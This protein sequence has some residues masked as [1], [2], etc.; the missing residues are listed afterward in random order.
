MADQIT[1]AIDMLQGAAP[2]TAIQQQQGSEEEGQGG[3]GEANA[4]VAEGT[5]APAEP[6]EQPK[7][8]EKTE[9]TPAPV[10]EEAQDD[11][12]P[13]DAYLSGGKEQQPQSP[14]TD[15]ARSVFK[16][17][18]GHEDPAAFKTEY[19]TLQEKARI[20][21]QRDSKLQTIEQN[22][23]K[24]PVEFEEAIA[25]AMQG[26]DPIDHIK[27]LGP[28]R[29]NTPA[30]KLDK[31]DLVNH[32]FKGKMTAERAEEV[33]NGEASAEYM[34]AFNIL[35]DQ[36]ADKHESLRQQDSQRAQSIKTEREEIQKRTQQSRL[37]SV[38]HFKQNNP[39]VAGMVD[40]AMIDRFLSGQLEGEL[41]RNADGSYKPEAFARL[42]IPGIHDKVMERVRQ[43]ALKNGKVQG[44]LEER[45]KKPATAPVAGG[46][47]NTP[48]KQAEEKT[49]QAKV[50]DALDQLQA[51]NQ[52][53][54]VNL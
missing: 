52:F 38:A 4:P 39:A 12:D 11:I 23:N 41:L 17:E 30:D 37:E 14:W 26:G 5:P 40:S 22:L 46:P 32:Y 28:V 36:A 48:A 25:L 16:A 43:G 1:S 21:E 27:N 7:E 33:R 45:S 13:I 8:G 50:A 6:T 9:E 47:R 44:A 15:E 31:V 42:V 51:G 54:S 53:I 20:L 19:L 24:L 34:D 29:L 49:P 18:F 2:V 10:T 35:A 3:Q